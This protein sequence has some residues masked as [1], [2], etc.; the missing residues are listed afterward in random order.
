VKAKSI[1]RVVYAIAS[2]CFVLACLGAANKGKPVGDA[3]RVTLDDTPE[4]QWKQQDISGF[5]ASIRAADSITVLAGLPYPEAEKDWYNHESKR[6]DLVWI[7]GYPFYPQPLKVS[8]QDLRQIKEVLLDPAAHLEFP[9]FMASLLTEDYHPSHA[10]VWSKGGQQFGSLIDLG[11]RHE[12][13]NFTP[14]Q[15][16]YGRI[17]AESHAKLAKVLGKFQQEHLARTEEHGSQ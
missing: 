14:S 6:T 16:L 3:I 8:D 4:S 11:C 10:V 12:W 15:T 17:A 7:L 1:E 2:G 13:K 9:Q 5:A